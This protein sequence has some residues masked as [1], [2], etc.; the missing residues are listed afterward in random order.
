MAHSYVEAF[1]SETDAFRTFAADFPGRTT[2]LVDIY[3]TVEG[4]HAAIEVIR[5]LGLE[6]HAGVRL[7]SGDLMA[8]A[9]MTRQ[10]LDDVGLHHVRIFVSGGL[11]EYDLQRFAVSRAPIDAAGV[12][13]QMGVS[14]DAPSLNSAYK[15]V[16]YDGRPVLKL[17]AGKM[18]M[19]GANQ[20]HRGA[21]EGRRRPRLATRGIGA[22]RQRATVGTGHVPRSTTRRTPHGGRGE[23]TIRA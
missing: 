15:L 19:P 23:G 5:E 21:L 6:E 17:S 3:D 8:R 22:P 2:F 9:W 4:V 20:V 14:G 13:H 12:A 7:D 11:D 16:V 1:P 18:T 10:L